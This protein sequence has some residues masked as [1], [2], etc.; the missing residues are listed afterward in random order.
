MPYLQQVSCALDMFRDN[1]A[2]YFFSDGFAKEAIE[3][4][5]GPKI[6]QIL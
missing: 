1:N 6:Y 4:D 5:I 3:G 2:V